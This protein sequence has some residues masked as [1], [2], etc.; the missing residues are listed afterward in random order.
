MTKL[1]EGLLLPPKIWCSKC[2]MKVRS[3]THMSKSKRKHKYSI[4][5][6]FKDTKRKY[7]WIME[8]SSRVIAEVYV[9][10]E[11]QLFVDYLSVIRNIPNYEL[12]KIL[13]KCWEPNK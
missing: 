3:C 2:K 5:K 1:E 10:K 9:L 6:P 7:W 13:V 12:F 11:A 8:D 4:E